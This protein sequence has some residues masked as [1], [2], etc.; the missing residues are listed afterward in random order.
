MEY[1]PMEKE[2]EA[3]RILAEK[4]QRR[5]GRKPKRMEAPVSRKIADGKQRAMEIVWMEM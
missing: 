4:T 5:E 3:A 2:R 1:L